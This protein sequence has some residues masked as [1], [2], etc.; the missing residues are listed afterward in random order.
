MAKKLQPTHS[1]KGFLTYMDYF[2]T[3]EGLTIEINF[4]LTDTAKQAK[5]KHLDRFI[6]TGNEH[7]DARAYFSQ[8]IEVMRIESKKAKELLKEH[9]TWGEGLHK[10]LCEAGIE[11]HFKVYYNHS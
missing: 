7:S 11:M 4:C 1:Y 8:G 2:A 3:G 9:F 6:G 5:E 10:H